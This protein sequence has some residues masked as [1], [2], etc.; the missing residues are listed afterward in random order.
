MEEPDM[1][2]FSFVVGTWEKAAI[3]PSHQSSGVNTICNINSIYISVFFQTFN[4][5]GER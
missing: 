2:V 1:E 5:V 4:W 3:H